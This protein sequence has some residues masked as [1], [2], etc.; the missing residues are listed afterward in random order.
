M[1][2]Y[3]E[4][5]HFDLYPENLD[6]RY[7]ISRERV[8][9]RWKKTLEENFQVQIDRIKNGPGIKYGWI[10]PEHPLEIFNL[11]FSELE[12]KTVEKYKSSPTRKALMEEFE[13]GFQYFTEID[14]ANE[15]LY[16][17]IWEIKNSGTLHL[18]DP[19]I[20]DL[21]LFNIIQ[22][23]NSSL[24]LVPFPSKSQEQSIP[25]IL[26][27]SEKKVENGEN[28]EIP[29]TYKEPIYVKLHLLK[30]FFSE[31]DEFEKLK[32][33]DQHA[34]LGLI[35]GCRADTV[36]PIKNNTQGKPD[37]KYVTE[38]AITRFQDLL[39]K[40]KKGETF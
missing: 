12:K 29:E 36:K 35:F 33:K 19:K 37:G 5:D 30:H 16:P 38:R 14:R 31:N 24:G 4:D 23:E 22:K 25:Q 34:L 28:V 10:Y 17:N 1:E 39:E 15:E 11:Y 20:P 26:L 32:I 13:T 6:Y 18:P 8:L 7:S 40:L 9:K 3:E 27:N 2:E 21:F